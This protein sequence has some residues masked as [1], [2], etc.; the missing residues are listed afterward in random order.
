MSDPDVQRTLG[1]LDARTT[2]L[3]NRMSVLER[4]IKAQLA[5]MNTQIREM[6]DVVVSAKGTWRAVSW[7]IVTITGASGALAAIWH[8]VISGTR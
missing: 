3:E 6:H 5:A 1:A 8:W 7:L 4:E 2:A